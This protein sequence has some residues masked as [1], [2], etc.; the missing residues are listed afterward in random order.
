MKGRMGSSST[1]VVLRGPKKANKKKKTSW[2]VRKDE[3]C[4]LCKEGI[5][6]GSTAYGSKNAPMHSGCNRKFKKWLR[7]GSHA[8]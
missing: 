1:V 2:K 3:V 5:P 6:E 7:E 8:R 4:K